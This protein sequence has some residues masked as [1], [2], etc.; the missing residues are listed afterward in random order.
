MSTD[1]LA[2]LTAQ[3]EKARNSARRM[4]PPRH[5]PKAATDPPA[6]IPAPVPAEPEDTSAAKRPQQ[7]PPVSIVPGLEV[8]EPAPPLTRSTIY[9]N[10]ESD[11]WLE[12]VATLGRRSK[13]RADASRSAVVRLAL[14][15]LRTD[16]TPAEVV[17]QLRARAAAAPNRAGRKR[18]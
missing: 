11:D 3:R 2:A 18:L 10:A 15:R 7:H 9:V 16:M 5:A 12:D 1:G 14:E 4:P 6:T 17:E 13:P 8:G